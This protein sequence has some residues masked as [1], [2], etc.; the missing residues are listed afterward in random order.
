M[1]LYVVRH[2]ESEANEKEILGSRMPFSLSEKGRQQAAIIAESFIKDHSPQLVVCS[3]LIRARETAEAFVSEIRRMESPGKL[4]DPLLVEREEIT[5]QQLGRYA[6]MSYSEIESAEG[7][8]HDRAARWDWIPEGGGE[9]YQMIAE[10]VKPF[11]TWLDSRSE[12]EILVVSHAV[13]MRLIRAH[14]EMT[15]PEYPLPI[16]RN[17]EI[18]KLEYRGYGHKHEIESLIYED[19]VPERRA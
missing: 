1:I 5:E 8:V 11:F 9:S 7:Y 3:P 2:A 13:T 16:A 17:G 14:L 18:W 6:G 4:S 15:L 12:K 19:V 10:R